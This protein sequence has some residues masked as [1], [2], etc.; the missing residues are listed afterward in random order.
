MMRLFNNLREDSDTVVPRAAHYKYDVDA[1]Q[2]MFALGVANFVGSFFSAYPM[3]GTV[4]RSAV[5][6]AAGSRYFTP[7]KSL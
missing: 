5:A 7:P 2:E 3:C 1:N 6:A 4:G